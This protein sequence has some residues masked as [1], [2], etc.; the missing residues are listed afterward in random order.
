MELVQHFPALNPAIEPICSICIAN[1]NGVTLLGD[2]IESVLSQQGGHS[3][4]IIVHD[5]ASTDGSVAWLRERYPQIELLASAQNVGFC[6]GNNRM[7][8]HAR[9]EFILLLNN[10]AALLPDA[11]SS[12]LD[13]ARKQIPP[14]IL[15]LPQYDWASGALVDR[16][17]L[18]DPFYNPIPNL[19]PKRTKVAMAIGAC[20]WIPHSLWLE[21]G[22]FPPW[23]ESIAEDLYLCCMARSRGFTVQTTNC[24]GFRHRLGA[25]FG[26]A[27]IDGNS[28]KST[29]RRRRLS[30]RNKTFVLILFTPTP[31]AWMLLGLHLLVLLIEGMVLSLVSKNFGILRHIYINVPAAL[32]HDRKQISTLR[33]QVQSARRVSL[34]TYLGPF[35]FLP[36]KLT[37]LLRYG[38]PKITK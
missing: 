26:G 33:R 29:F 15:T 27:R 38:M 20:L 3:I 4:E 35:S 6:I 17:C 8:T 22:G 10:D 37:M 34:M 31:A 12:L 24:S 21:L 36:R 32:A 16:G 30:E 1:Y 5:D 2:C 7:V 18:L 25:S 28:L 23:L 14:G 13:A 9:G 11:L 19:D